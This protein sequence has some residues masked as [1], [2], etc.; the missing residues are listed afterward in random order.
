MSFPTP[1]TLTPRIALAAILALSPLLIPAAAVGAGIPTFVPIGAGGNTAETLEQFA[2][3]AAEVDTS[4]QVSILVLPI[5]YGVDPLAMSNGLR[6]KNLTLADTRRGQIE[7]VCLAAIP[8]NETCD[9]VLA[10]V[11]I[12]SD[13]YVQSNIDLVKAGLDGIYVLGGDQVVGMQVV[14]NTPFEAAL[15]QRQSEGA[16]TSGN[17][18]GAAVELADMIAGYT[19]SSG[20]EQGIPARCGRPLGVRGTDR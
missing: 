18:A 16:V 13:A 7:D 9:V 11:L 15:A 19:G 6:N 12:R 1:R 17:S 5:T 2:A 14:V 8:A 10:P 3:E 20:P 4:G